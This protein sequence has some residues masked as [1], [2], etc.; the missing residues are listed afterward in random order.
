MTDAPNAATIPPKRIEAAQAAL[1]AY[2]QARGFDSKPDEDAID[3]L[4]DLLHLSEHWNSCFAADV[5][6]R[7]A[8]L[9]Y[10]EEANP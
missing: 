10:Q 9:H 6:H 8:W 1:D 2:R 7:L 4:V 3:L 5:I